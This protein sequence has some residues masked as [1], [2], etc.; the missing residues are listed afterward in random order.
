MPSLP[1]QE[2]KGGVRV[3]GVMFLESGEVERVGYLN[4]AWQKMNRRKS[5]ILSVSCR[6]PRVPDVRTRW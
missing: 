1:L 3:R 4:V 2:W 6:A 5:V